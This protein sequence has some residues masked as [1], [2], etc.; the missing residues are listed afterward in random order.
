MRRLLFVLFMFFFIYVFFYGYPSYVKWAQDKNGSA[1]RENERAKTEAEVKAEQ[2]NRPSLVGKYQQKVTEQAELKYLGPEEILSQYSLALIS[3]KMTERTALYTV[4]TAMLIETMNVSKT[5]M[6]SEA[7]NIER[8][9]PG[10]TIMNNQFAVIRFPAVRRDCSPYFFVY[11]DSQWRLDLTMM[12]K[13]IRFNQNNLWHF[14]A[15]YFLDGSPYGFAFRDWSF[16][17]HGYPVIE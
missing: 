2:V 8:C 14:D 6:E 15:Y 17:E 10:R 4:E 13:A 12:H 1:M 3:H 9:L 5:Q 7:Y 11:E 16:D